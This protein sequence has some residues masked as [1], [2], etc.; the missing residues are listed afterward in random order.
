MP[1]QNEQGW[2]SVREDDMMEGILWRKV[3]DRGELREY[4]QCHHE[5]FG[6]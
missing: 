5:D 2:C 6:I 4:V 3:G 1:K